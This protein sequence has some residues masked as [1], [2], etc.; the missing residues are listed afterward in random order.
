MSDTEPL[1]DNRL[2]PQDERHPLIE[3]LRRHARRRPE[4]AACCAEMTAFILSSRDCFRRTHALGHLTGSAWLLSPEGD[5]ALL[6]LHRKL[7]RWL[8][9]GGHADGDADL[10]RV[11]LREAE[12]ESGI[13]G[14]HPLSTDIFDV[15]IHLIPARPG[16][17]EHRHYDVR[18]LLRAPHR[19]F[20]CSAESEALAWLPIARLAS[21][22]AD[23]DPSVARM[24]RLTQSLHG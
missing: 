3:A 15:D 10:L 9:P 12:E 2:P 7:K 20:V 16:E 23:V 18:Y 24:A 6:T 22:H 17:P 13:V 11:A 1:A 4:Q 5:A 21:P 8:Q 19:R 14:I